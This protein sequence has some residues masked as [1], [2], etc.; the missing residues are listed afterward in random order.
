MR[1]LVACRYR[2]VQCPQS[3]KYSD[4]RINLK[5]F[6]VSGNTATEPNVSG[7]KLK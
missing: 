3:R 5:P 6:E 2:K 1:A 7:L 4:C